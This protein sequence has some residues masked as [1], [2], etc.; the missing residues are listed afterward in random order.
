[1]WD[2]W[3]TDF[4][5]QNEIYCDANAWGNVATVVSTTN[6]QSATCQLYKIAHIA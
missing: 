2:N 1:M 6:T 3:F 4:P 5:L